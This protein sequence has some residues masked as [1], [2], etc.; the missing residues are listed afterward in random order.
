[1]KMN[2]PY[3][4][5]LDDFVD[6]IEIEKISKYGIDDLISKAKRLREEHLKEFKK[7][8]KQ[9]KER[10]KKEIKELLDSVKERVRNYEKFRKSK[11]PLTAEDFITDLEI[12]FENKFGELK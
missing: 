2:E 9:E 4:D 7:T 10:R 11:K 3:R 5:A 6:L 1:M 12:E 8:E